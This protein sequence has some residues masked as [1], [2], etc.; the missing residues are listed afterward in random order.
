METI[1]DIVAEM[2]AKTAK[3]KDEAWYDKDKWAELCNRIE[4]AWEREAKAI[5]TENAVLPAVCITKPVGN[6]AK[7]REALFEI[8]SQ[9][10]DR[11]ARKV[12]Y[13]RMLFRIKNIINAAL[14]A[15]PRN[16]D[17]PSVVED[18]YSAWLYDR[19]N[20]DEL[21]DPKKEIHE[22]LLAEAKGESDEHKQ[23]EP[24]DSLMKEINQAFIY[25]GLPKDSKPAK[26]LRNC[27]RYANRKEAFAEWVLYNSQQKI[28]VI[29]WVDFVDWLFAEAKG[30]SEK[31]VRCDD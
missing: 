17:I 5:A 29:R 9:L 11:L 4:M 1:S 12:T 3:S 20:W 15:H 2:R 25:G 23:N 14:S 22:W 7:M 28:G 31:E 6:E 8:H 21:G 16:C 24:L 27:D 26:T 19:D 30:E 10:K 13:E 18:S